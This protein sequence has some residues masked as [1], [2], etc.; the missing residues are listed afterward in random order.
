MGRNCTLIRVLAAVCAVAIPTGSLADNAA[1]P[2]N[3]R[4]VID[5]KLASYLKDPYSAVKQVTRGPRYGAIKTGVF[6]HVYGWG[7]CYSINAKNSYGGYAGARD[8]LIVIDEANVVSIID[9]DEDTFKASLIERECGLPADV[10]KPPT[11]AS[12]EHI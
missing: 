10:L 1:P 11:E 5:T 2:A 4:Q 8:F 9:G 3:W 12:E 7:V 6:Q